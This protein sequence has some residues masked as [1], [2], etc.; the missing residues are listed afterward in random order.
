MRRPRRDVRTVSEPEGLLCLDL[1]KQLAAA[2]RA[3]DIL[4]HRPGYVGRSRSVLPTGHGLEG[5]QVES[6]R[7]GLLVDASSDSPIS[8]RGVF[9]A[10]QSSAPICLGFCFGMNS[11]AT[12][13][14]AL[15]WMA[16][17]RP[18]YARRFLTAPRQLHSAWSR[19]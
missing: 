2:G 19:A 6:L 14:P 16:P 10:A 4:V 8:R 13:A 7:I 1:S 11:S 5:H 3:R 15:R 12:L 9:S 17:S 18:S